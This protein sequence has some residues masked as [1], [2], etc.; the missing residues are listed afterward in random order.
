MDGAWRIETHRVEWRFLMS[1]GHASR[2]D[3][4]IRTDEDTLI[5]RLVNGVA[6]TGI[7]SYRSAQIEAWKREIRLLKEQLSASQFQNW[8]IILE[9]ELPRRSRRPDMI[10]LSSKTI[11][12][13]EFKIG[14][15]AYDSV[16]CLQVN[17]Y[18][19]DLR[20]FHA[21]S[22][23]HRIVPILCA[24]NAAQS[25]QDE[26]R[27]YRSETEVVD[28]VRTNGTNLSSRLLW[29]DQ[30]SDYSPHNPIDPESWLNSA[31]RPTP[32]IIEAAVRLYEGNGVREL[33]HRHAH[34]LDQTT[35]MLVREIEN[36]RSQGNRVICFVTGIPGAG[37]TLTGL[38]V[39]HDQSLRQSDSLAGIFLSGNGPLIKIVREALVKSQVN[40]GRKKQDCEHEVSTFIQNVHKFLQFHREDP[41]E[42]PHENVVVFD[43][44]QRAWDSSQMMRKQNVKASEATLLFE[45][46]ER[47]PDWAVIIALVG[48]GQEIFLGEAGLEEWGRA[49]E[50]RSV[51]WQ[52]VAAK[53][54]LVGGDSVAGHRLFENGIPANLSYKEEPLAHLDVVVRSHR[55]QRW[56]EWVNELLSLRLDTARS[57]FP[58]TQEFPCFI[59]RNIQNTRTWLRMLYSLYPEQ[60]I[61]LVATSIDQ[62]LRAYGIERSS[63]FRSNYAF[64]KWFLNP[65]DDIRSSYALEVAASEFEC[66]GLELDWVGMCWGGDLTP[67]KGY[68]TWD[69]RKFRGA[70]WQ[71]V[72]KA[73]ERAYTEN[74]YRVLLTRARNGIV[75]WVPNGDPNDP[76]RD[77]DRFDRVFKVLREAGVPLLEEY[78]SE[79]GLQS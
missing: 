70:K 38:D 65:D 51:K 52:V 19:R 22:Q 17:R 31:Y 37:K 24:T 33:S 76:T 54:V 30:Q 60:R 8:F 79:Y 32:T 74:R 28:L 72:K 39:V 61:G 71:T 66:Q 3:C 62:R 55:A 77:P 57:L 73:E 15:Q 59:T 67:S 4:F 10:L 20:D 23:E 56:A 43:E 35:E 2:I 40:R 26:V 69:Y 12:V 6:A 11:F 75:I 36:A 64:E 21:E 29:C 5:G 34:N 18:A 44:A 48:G 49:I 14:A 78:F 47:L 16:S 9:Y 7:S 63:A 58:D 13:V 42:C 45:V 53:E 46:M 68:S 50:K 1:Y 25:S 41:T 27:F